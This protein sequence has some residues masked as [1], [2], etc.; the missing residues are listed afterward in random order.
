MVRVFKKQFTVLN[1]IIKH[2]MWS[3]FWW[4]T[5]YVYSE[6]IFTLYVTRQ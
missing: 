3:G 5:I 4:L 1:P 2:K 6:L